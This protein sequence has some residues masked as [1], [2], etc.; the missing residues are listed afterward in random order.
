[1]DE[2][3]KTIVSM[4]TTVFR[5]SDVYPS[6]ETTAPQPSSNADQKE[7]YRNDNI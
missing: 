7:S 5:I 3:S 4:P 6:S 2:S 1:M